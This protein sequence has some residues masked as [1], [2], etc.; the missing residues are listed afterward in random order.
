[1]CLLGKEFSRLC[2]GRQRSHANNWNTSVKNFG[3]VGQL[4]PDTLGMQSNQPLR[5]TQKPPSY[6]S[7]LPTSH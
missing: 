3:R 5:R 2:S 4:A 6:F 7:N 1:M